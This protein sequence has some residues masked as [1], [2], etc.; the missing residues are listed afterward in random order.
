[1]ITQTG[2]LAVRI[3]QSFN[4]FGILNHILFSLQKQSNLK[5]QR[6]N[7]S[8]TMSNIFQNQ[9]FKIGIQIFLIQLL[10]LRANS[11]YDY[12]ADDDLDTTT[13]QNDKSDVIPAEDLG[14][15]KKGNLF[16]RFLLA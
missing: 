15:E 2:F 16:Q 10:L 9:L 13:S 1:M 11:N 5:G 14:K 7:T 12:Y 3:S 8:E 6:E 4:C